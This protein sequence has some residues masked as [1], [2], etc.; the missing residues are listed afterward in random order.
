M[1]LRVPTGLFD[2]KSVA[3]EGASA[4]T[5]RERGVGAWM[6]ISATAAAGRVKY[7]L[8]DENLST[9][10]VAGD[11]GHASE[12]RLDASPLQDRSRSTR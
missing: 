7:F 11:H 1:H 6:A 5:I 10:S 2:S 3:A 8:R 9:I 4:G 12:Q